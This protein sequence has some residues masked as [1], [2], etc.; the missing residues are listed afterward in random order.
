[1]SPYGLAGPAGIPPGIVKVL[2]EAFKI[3]M[4][5]PAFRAELARYDQEPAYLGPDDY[6]RALRAAYEHERQ[7]VDRL[8]LSQGPETPGR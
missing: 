1:M 5:D 3:A 6:G 8:G 7:V 4:N 2:H